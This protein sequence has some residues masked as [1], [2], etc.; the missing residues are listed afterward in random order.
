M[1]DFLMVENGRLSEENA[2]LTKQLAIAVAE[3]EWLAKN[4][5]EISTRTYAKVALAKIKEV[6]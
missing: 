1:S 2:R 6:E 3:Y 4:A 5:G